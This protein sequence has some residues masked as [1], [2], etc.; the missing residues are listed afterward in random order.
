MT[1]GRKREDSVNIEINVQFF[2]R[3]MKTRSW[4][5]KETTEME[6]LQRQMSL[7]SHPYLP[8]VAGWYSVTWYI[9]LKRGVGLFLGDCGIMEPARISQLG[10]CQTVPQNSVDQTGNTCM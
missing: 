6:I 4:R 5:E 2:L 1:I 7:L 8:F 10:S 3:K 9:L